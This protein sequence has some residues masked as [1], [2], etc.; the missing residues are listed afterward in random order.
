MSLDAPEDFTT[1]YDR[2][3]TVRNG[4]EVQLRCLVDSFP[5]ATFVWRLDGGGMV[6]NESSLNVTVEEEAVYFCDAENPLGNI[7][8]QFT[9]KIIRKCDNATICKI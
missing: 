6:G 8:F 7:T 4:T 5:Q 9:V 1:V 2:T 3:I